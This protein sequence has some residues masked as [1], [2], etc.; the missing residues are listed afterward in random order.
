MRIYDTVPKSNSNATNKVNSVLK[1]LE[2]Q[3]IKKKVMFEHI[4]VQEKC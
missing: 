2:V 4:V 3:F 1:L